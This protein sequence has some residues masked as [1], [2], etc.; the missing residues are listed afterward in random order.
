MSLMA[1]RP[2]GV[3]NFLL[4]GGTTMRTTQATGKSARGWGRN[5]GPP[6]KGAPAV[7]LI[8]Q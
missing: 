6:G 3:E 5:T 4:T 2:R 7:V 1:P 8:G